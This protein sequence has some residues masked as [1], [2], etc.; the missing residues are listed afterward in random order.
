MTT[1]IIILQ[2]AL[3]KSLSYHKYSQKPILQPEDS[4]MYWN[5]LE[6]TDKTID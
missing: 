2:H 5:R 4:L 1:I 6:T 3:E